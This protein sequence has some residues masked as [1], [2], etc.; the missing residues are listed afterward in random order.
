M[1]SISLD[2]KYLLEDVPI[3]LSGAQAI[4]RLAIDQRRRDADEGYRTAGFLSGYRGSPLG[5]VDTAL[6]QAAAI[7][8]THDIHFEPGLNEEIAATA[9]SGSQQVELFGSRC[10]G[11]FGIWY[12][13]NP[14]LD[15]A[16][17]ALKHANA[18]GTAA[19]GGVL[20]IVGDDPG[21][22]SS[23]LP[24]QCDHA[25]IS[26]LIPVLSPSSLEEVI[27]F[28]LIGFSLSRYSGL[29]TG[30]KAVA[31]TIECTGSISAPGR[32]FRCSTPDDFEL[33]PDGLGARWPDE[34]WDQDVRLLKWRLPAARAFARANGL[35]R[36]AFGRAGGRMTIV[37]SGKAYNDVRQ[38]LD[39]LG[40]DEHAANALG[41]AVYKVGMVWP[42]EGERIREA[43]EGVEEVVVVE[44]RRA[45]IEPQ[46]K[47]IAY[48]W[49][50]DRRPLIV[51]KRDEAMCMLLPEEGE[52]SPETVALA[53]GDRLARLG[54][55]PGSATR[56]HVLRQ[57]RAEA[58]PKGPITGRTPHFCSGCPHARSTRV[59][60][61]D[62][63]MAGIGCH[64]LRVWMPNSQ[65]MILPQMGGEG[66]SWL[67][68]APFTPKTHVFQNLG[69]GTFVHSGS[70]AIRAAVAAKRNMTFRIFCNQATGMTGGQPLEG[71]L[72]VA[73]IVRQVAAE[74]VARIAVV[75]AERKRY[76]RDVT[77]TRGVSIHHRNE[78]ENVQRELRNVQ[79]VSAIVYDQICATEKRRLV[80]RGK[81]PAPQVRPFINSRVCEGCGDCGEVSNCAA[82]LPLDTEL[83][84]KRRI[85]QSSCNVD[86][87]CLEGFCPSFVTVQGAQVRRARPVAEVD[88]TEL[89]PPTPLGS[90]ADVI[91]VGVGGTG[92]MTI[93]AVAGMAA[94]LAGR[95]C[96]VLDNTG[97]ARKGGAVSSHIR[98][99]SH[100]ERIASPRIPDCKASLVLACDAIAAT[101]PA[102]L[103]KIERDRTQV[104]ANADIV[105]TFGQR[106]DPDA[107]FAP[108]PI[109]QR[110]LD[111]AGD[112]RCEFI[113]AAAMAER[114][115]GD[116]IYANMLMFGYAFQKGFVPLPAEAIEEAILLNGADVPANKRAFELGRRTALAEVRTS[117]DAQI[118][119]DDEPLEAMIERLAAFLVDYQDESYAQRFRDVVA[120][121]KAAEKVAC[122]D[123]DQ[124]TRAVAR[125][126]FRLMAI[127]DEYEIG[128]LYTDGEFD[129]SLRAQ[130]SEPYRISYHFA[131]RFLPLRNGANG[132]PGKWT[133]GPWMRPVLA[134]LSAM[135]G[136]R[137]TPFDVFGWSA[138]R[139]RERRLIVEYQDLVGELMRDLGPGNH[140]LAVEIA[141]LFEDIRGYGAVRAAGSARVERRKSELMAVYRERPEPDA[142][143]SDQPGGRAPEAGVA[144][145]NGLVR[146]I[147]G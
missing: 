19:R 2:D 95:A 65:T 115:L 109:R 145:G 133:F 136:L 98:I 118:D 121:A 102:M 114:S 89:P 20:A 74:G 27:R 82:I 131:P 137:G 13:K 113:E 24:N 71:G 51:G 128:R 120:K 84:R 106:L 139:R 16:L 78:Y 126:L 130:F 90:D 142:P 85:D 23:S 54:L 39:G 80:K 47:D 10:D 141:G 75:S 41:L 28:G 62:V 101:A 69:D 3:F 63:A 134:A 64:S 76:A 112:D 21:A 33:P 12:A 59:L 29:W 146:E 79:G 88:R 99:A 81:V 52:L 94:H 144:S 147:I 35:D 127:K 143:R 45:V 34:R 138:E 26:A 44:E 37:T 22:A 140:H 132:R 119:R 56:L 15:R 58:R 42:L 103:A 36:I 8:K 123:R 43:V 83:G 66:A 124:F 122:N 14:G 97:M 46:L 11:V 67:G 108:M 57:R 38:A 30:I 129:R 53:I 68:I 4:A 92:V 104:I 125:S 91:V 73:D 18:V 49:P 25:F 117:A 5:G 32:S 111:V 96:S 77:R 135:R 116:S 61:G 6:W 72:G 1:R 86:L 50:A 17:D 48:N 87:S 55:S 7:L 40:I 9:V 31:D 93:G 107:V 60:E 70:L 100:P 105:P 110:L